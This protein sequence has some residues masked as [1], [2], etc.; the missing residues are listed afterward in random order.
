[1]PRLNRALEK[2]EL[3]MLAGLASQTPRSLEVLYYEGQTHI[4]LPAVN[5]ERYELALASVYGQLNLVPAPD[6]W[7][8]ISD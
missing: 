8:L 4:L 7:Q 2:D 5:M 1:M 3:A 6:V